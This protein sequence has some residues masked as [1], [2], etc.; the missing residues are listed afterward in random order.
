LGEGKKEIERDQ[1]LTSLHKTA[2]KRFYAPPAF[3]HERITYYTEVS[4]PSTIPNT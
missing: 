4:L 2:K 3:H 1:L